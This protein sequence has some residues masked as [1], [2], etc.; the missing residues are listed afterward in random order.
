MGTEAKD[1]YIEQI[2]LN[3]CVLTSREVKYLA[4]AALG[5]HNYQIAQILYVSFYTVRKTLEKIFSKLHTIDR[6]NAVAIAFIHKILS[7]EILMQI[8][9]YYDI[10]NQV[11]CR[12][13]NYEFCSTK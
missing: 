3:N 6:A 8:I 12:E 2:N 11:Y 9:K 4:L 1:L 10:N 5:Y 13:L 7:A